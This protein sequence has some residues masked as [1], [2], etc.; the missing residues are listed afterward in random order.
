MIARYGL[1]EYKKYQV[2]FPCFWLSFYNVK[3]SMT[4]RTRNV[5]VQKLWIGL[6]TNVDACAHPLYR[7]LPATSSTM[8]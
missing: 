2:S 7:Q 5:H 4:F 6:Y 3:M 8:D 1:E